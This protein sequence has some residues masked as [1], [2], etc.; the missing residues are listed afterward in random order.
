MGSMGSDVL[1]MRSAGK[2]TTSSQGT[3]GGAYTTPHRRMRGRR[4]RGEEEGLRWGTIA[5]TVRTG[6]GRTAAAEVLKGCRSMV[7]V[8]VM[9][10]GK[11]K[12]WTVVRMVAVVIYMAK[13]GNSSSNRKIRCLGRQSQ[14]RPRPALA[15]HHQLRVEGKNKKFFW[16][17]SPIRGREGRITP[18]LLLFQ[19]LLRR[20]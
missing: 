18:P 4:R 7:V 15:G 17:N 10:G 16:I 13:R 2:G 19:I 1:A 12:V 14:G 5:Y 6:N 8:M 9:V 11:V 3:A 20:R